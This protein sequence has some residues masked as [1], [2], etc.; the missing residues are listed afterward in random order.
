MKITTIILMV[1]LSITACKPK[2]KSITTT[3]T[4]AVARDY[5]SPTLNQKLYDNQTFLIEEYSTDPNYGYTQENPVM[6]GGAKNSEGPLNERRFLN[7]LAGPNGEKISYY[8]IG[9]CC[10]FKT[11]NSGWNGMLDKYN[12]SYSGLKEDIV[13]FINMYDSDTL[14]VPMGFSLVY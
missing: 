9:S 10:P 7:A 2:Q 14:K 13:I 11:N 1:L 3:E 8:R 12:V 4:S 6:V 5:G